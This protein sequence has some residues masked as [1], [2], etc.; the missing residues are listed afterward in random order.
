[1]NWQWVWGILFI[2]RTLPALCSGRTVLVETVD[3][4]EPPVL[5][6]FIIATWIALSLFLIVAD[7]LMIMGMSIV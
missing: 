6:W 2:M 5:F 7:F 3:R 4:D 1:M